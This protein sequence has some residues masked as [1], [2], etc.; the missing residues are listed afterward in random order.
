MYKQQHTNIDP[1]DFHDLLDEIEQRV[2]RAQRKSAAK[3]IYAIMVSGP[4]VILL[5]RLID[6]LL[7]GMPNGTD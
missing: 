1:R 2:Y 3:G 6:I 4:I 7:P 5:L